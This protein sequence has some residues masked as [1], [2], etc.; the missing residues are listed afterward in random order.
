MW[1]LVQSICIDQIYWSALIGLGPMTL[2]FLVYQS[3]SNMG[4]SVYEVNWPYLL[5]FLRC[6]FWS[7]LSASIWSDD[8]H[9]SA[10]NLW[11]LTSDLDL[12]GVPISNIETSL[13]EVIDPICCIFWD[14]IYGP[15][16]QHRSDLMI[17]TDRP[18]TYDPDRLGPCIS[19]I[20]IPVYKVS[21]LYLLYFLIY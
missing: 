16:Y 18:L 2:T 14:V 1:L 15:V 8:Q 6:Y 21:W 9:W 20:G 4:T 5:H 19:D 10:F 17:S 11:P 3:I 7:S 13:Y 12:F